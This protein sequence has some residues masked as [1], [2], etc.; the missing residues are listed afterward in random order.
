[1]SGPVLIVAGPTA[2]GKSQLAATVAAAFDG[3]VIN[4]DS[5]QVYRELRV[6]TARPDAALCARVPHRLYGIVPA[7]ER[8]STGAWRSRALDEIAT[9]EAAG[10]LPVLCGGTGL[11][12]RALTGGLADIP[13][14]PDAIRR[15]TDDLIGQIGA[16]ALH[17]R[18]AERDPET[19]RRLRPSDQQRVARAWA[20][21]EAT[22]RPLAEW[23]AAPAPTPGVRRFVHIVLLPPR[24]LLY[25]ACDRRFEAM[26]AQGA[27][28]EVR[29]LLDLGLA[30]NL[31][32][33]KA[34]G[35][36]ELGDYL[37]GDCDLASAVR[38]A[39]QATRRYAKRQLTWLRHQV[40]ADHVLKT[41]FSERICP[42]IFSFIR[43]FL[44]TTADERSTKHISHV[45][46]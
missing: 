30:A 39:Q 3:V 35:V 9:A 6:L 19:A 10:R 25:A 27:L 45:Q 11:Y 20:V 38:R 36:R 22:G 43:E 21:L 12:L 42:E 17:A 44:L 40:T 31:P 2:S 8:F 14:V 26:V 1:M 7:R 18:L 33:M 34:V 37:A 24:D 4:A 15:E 41:Q 28:E 32:A 16:A 29:R 5:M 23:Q 46:Q 13:P